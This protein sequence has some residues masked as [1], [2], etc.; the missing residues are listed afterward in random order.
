MT[1]DLI[2]QTITLFMF[3]LVLAALETQIEGAA[4]WAANLPTWRPAQTTWYSRLYRKIVPGKDITGYH[5]LIGGLV[6]FFLHYPYF[7]SQ[8]W[9]WSSE[10][11]TL[12]LFFL[13]IVVWDFLWFVI[14]PKYDF[15][16]FWSEQ[17]WWHKT[18]FLHF[19]LDYWLGFI[20]SALLY[21]QFSLNWPLFKEWLE[22]VALFLVL[23]LLAVVFAIAVGVFKIKENTDK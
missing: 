15:R 1:P 12:A 7:V 8:N 14:N 6:L 20:V 18:W 16:Q 22:V 21:V 23:T 19:P 17:V 4:G 13:V 3:C 2:L 9:S 10:L 11:T 5:M